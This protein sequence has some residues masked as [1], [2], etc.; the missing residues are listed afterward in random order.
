MQ[1]MV[2][3]GVHYVRTFYLSSYNEFYRY[4]PTTLMHITID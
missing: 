3:V 4:F 2:E 1:C